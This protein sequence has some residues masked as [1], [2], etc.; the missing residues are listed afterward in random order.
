MVIGYQITKSN[1]SDGDQSMTTEQ[2][3]A[4]IGPRSFSDDFTTHTCQ[5]VSILYDSGFDSCKISINDTKLSMIIPTQD[6]FSPADLD[7]VCICLASLLETF[8]HR[9]LG[10]E[11]LGAYSRFMISNPVQESILNRRRKK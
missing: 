8:G 10:R 1:F 5:S 7:L 3:L 11:I 2:Q 9:E 4:I 6:A